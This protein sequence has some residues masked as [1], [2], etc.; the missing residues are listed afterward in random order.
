MLCSNPKLD[1]HR[2]KD[3]IDE[4]IAAGRLL[5]L[6][7]ILLSIKP[8]QVLICLCIPLFNICRRSEINKSL[9]EMGKGDCRNGTS[10]ES[11]EDETE[12]SFYLST[13]ST[14]INAL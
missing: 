2:F 7:I 6:A 14:P 5:F 11:P 4:A 3:I 8:I 10:H 1:S 9:Q 13:F 12:V